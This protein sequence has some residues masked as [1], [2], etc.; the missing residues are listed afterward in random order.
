M[1][2]H[3]GKKNI[4]LEQVAPPA[5]ILVHTTLEWGCMESKMSLYTRTKKCYFWDVLFQALM[6]VHVWLMLPSRYF[7]RPKTRPAQTLHSSTKY[8]ITV[9]ASNTVWGL[10]TRLVMLRPSI[11]NSQ[12]LF[13][14]FDMFSSWSLAWSLIPLDMFSN[15]FW[16]TYDDISSTQVPPFVHW[17]YQH[18]NTG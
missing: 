15:W 7:Y 10:R 1:Q 3:H 8:N 16:S 2:L 12:L 13:P 5:G 18:L 17:L 6:Y 9:Q 4:G 11:F 14:N